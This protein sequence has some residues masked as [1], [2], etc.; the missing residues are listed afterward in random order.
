MRKEQTPR[1]RL[2]HLL[3]YMR[4]GQQ[5][6]ISGKLRCSPQKVSAVLNGKCNQDSDLA[7]NII[8]L[9]EECVRRN[10]MRYRQ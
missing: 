1:Y 3:T 10:S 8:R 9:A 6:W 2:T 5:G 7:R 4:R